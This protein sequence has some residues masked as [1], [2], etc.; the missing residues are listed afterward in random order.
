[1]KAALMIVDMQ[2]AYF[3][4]D[5]LEAKRVELTEACD[6]LII[7]ARKHD[8]PVVNIIT[9][10]KNDGSTWTLNMRE[11][12][13]GYLFED[14]EDSEVV[15]GLDI[16]DAVKVVKT[17]DSA[18]YSTGLAE[19]LHQQ[20]IDTIILAGVSTH[21]CIFQTAA[22]AYA[23]DLKV[24]LARDAIASHDPKFHDIALEMLTTEYRQ[25]NL[26]NPRIIELMSK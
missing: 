5:A 12:E 19:M 14:H 13:Q 10:H 16:E 26:S 9:K 1:M 21:T 25:P 4:N 20:G 18:F 22:D 15:D 2:K 3:N 7:C 24:I 17:R 11:D 8:V 23:S 6:E